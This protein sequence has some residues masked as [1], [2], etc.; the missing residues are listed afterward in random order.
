MKETESPQDFSSGSNINCNDLINGS[1]GY[2]YFPCFLSK[3]Q[4]IGNLNP[5]INLIPSA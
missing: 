4:G 2:M 5:A 1:L 3:A